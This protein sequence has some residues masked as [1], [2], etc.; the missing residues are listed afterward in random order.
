VDGH[1]TFS[2]WLTLDAGKDAVVEFDLTPNQINDKGF[3]LH[4]LVGPTYWSQP[5][6]ITIGNRARKA[7]SVTLAVAEGD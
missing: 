5:H 4:E 7:L 3:I 6:D 2:Q 1:E